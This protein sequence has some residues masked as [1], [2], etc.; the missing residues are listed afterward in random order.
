MV[1]VEDSALPSSPEKARNGATSAGCMEEGPELCG[2]CNGR[3][4]GEV[5]P[6]LRAGCNGRNEEVVRGK[7]ARTSTPHLE[8]VGKEDAR[9]EEKHA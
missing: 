6:E 8:A 5:R 3:N 2:R 7:R 1:L 4:E 9:V